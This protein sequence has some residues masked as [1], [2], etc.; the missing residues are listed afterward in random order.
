M[1]KKGLTK[2]KMK[3]IDPQ[4]FVLRCKYLKVPRAYE[5]LNPVLYGITSTL[6]FEANSTVLDTRKL[7]STSYFKERS[8]EA[9]WSGGE[10][11][12][13]E[14]WTS[15]VIRFPGSPKKLDG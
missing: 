14:P 2:V 7:Q 3:G 8:P 13:L 4:K 12:G 15:D 10:C 6:Y 9:L 5:S 1:R 11:Q